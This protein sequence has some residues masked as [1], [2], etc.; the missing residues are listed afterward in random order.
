[1]PENTASVGCIVPIFR[2]MGLNDKAVA[3][4]QWFAEHPFYKKVDAPTS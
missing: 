2:A 4:E 3:L 1:M